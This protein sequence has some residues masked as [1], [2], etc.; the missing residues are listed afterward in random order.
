[1]G[2]LEWLAIDLLEIVPGFFSRLYIT[3]GEDGS[4]QGSL[5]GND[6][7]DK[8]ANIAIVC[9]AHLDTAITND[10]HRLYKSS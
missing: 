1:M 5:V 10:R 4:V 8:S 9:Q 3:I 2:F 6:P 7:G